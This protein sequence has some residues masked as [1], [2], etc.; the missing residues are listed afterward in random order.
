MRL[1]C[2]TQSMDVFAVTLKE[3]LSSLARGQTNRVWV[4]K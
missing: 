3:A 2:G 1:S 4:E